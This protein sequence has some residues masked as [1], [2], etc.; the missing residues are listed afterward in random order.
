[1]RVAASKAVDWDFLTMYTLLSMVTCPLFDSLGRKTKTSELS[2]VNSGHVHPALREKLNFSADIFPFM[3]LFTVICLHEPDPET[4]AEKTF[5]KEHD[6][7]MTSK[8]TKFS[9][10]GQVSEV[11]QVVLSSGLTTTSLL[12]EAA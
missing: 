9:Q 7:D 4:E 3:F 12:F 11:E 6:L 2:P 10:T 5:E 1:M 8:E